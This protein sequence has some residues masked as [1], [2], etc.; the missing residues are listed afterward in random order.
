MNH[1]Q[2][3][4]QFKSPEKT[5]ELLDKL[6]QWIE[7]NT[8]A[9]AS[10]R[11]GVS[12]RF[13]SFVVEYAS[14]LTLSAADHVHVLWAHLTGAAHKSAERLH[15]GFWCAIALARARAL[16][17]LWPRVLGRQRAL[18]QRRC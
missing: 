12:L 9:P 2:M 8:L 10:R 15:A 11:D 18:W 4:V 1:S 16:R 14:H 6:E 17:P 5:G 13:D 3:K 7:H